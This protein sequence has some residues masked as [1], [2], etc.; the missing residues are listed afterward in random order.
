MPSLADPRFGPHCD[1]LSGTTASFCAEVELRRASARGPH[2][3]ASE[4][5]VTAQGPS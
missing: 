5:V 4:G 2:G 3:G 1:R